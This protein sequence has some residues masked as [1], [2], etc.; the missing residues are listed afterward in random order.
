MVLFSLYLLLFLLLLLI[1]Y[2]YYDY[3]RNGKRRPYGKYAENN[4]DGISRPY[5]SERVKKVKSVNFRPWT[6]NRVT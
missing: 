5:G 3:Y 2:Y 6:V 4:R 1:Y